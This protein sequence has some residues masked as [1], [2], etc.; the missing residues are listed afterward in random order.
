MIDRYQN[1][2]VWLIVVLVCLWFL[3]LA[4][5]IAEHVHAWPFG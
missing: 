5:K 2:F 4:Y 3:Y 1:T